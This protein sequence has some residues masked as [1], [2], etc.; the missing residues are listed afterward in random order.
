LL[1]LLMYESLLLLLHLSCEPYSSNHG[2]HLI[3]RA[4]CR[5]T[6]SKAS[7]PVALS[8]RCFL[9]LDMT[10]HWCWS[11]CNAAALTGHEAAR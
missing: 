4:C 1:L 2:V 6:F 5:D 8:D 3:K 9:R 10:L 7:T 11:C